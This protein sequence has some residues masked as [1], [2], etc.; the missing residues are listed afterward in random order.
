[1]RTKKENMK[2]IKNDI[3]NKYQYKNY[4]IYEKETEDGYEYYIQNE[5]YG[6]ISFM[7]GLTKDNNEQN[8]IIVYNNLESYIQLYQEKYED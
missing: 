8:K 2:W 4:V 1:M 6:I 7:F 5:K 3:I